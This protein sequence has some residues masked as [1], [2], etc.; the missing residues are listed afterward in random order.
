MNQDIELKDIRKLPR[1]HGETISDEYLD[2]MGHMN[3]QWY[4]ALFSKAVTGLFNPVSY[5]HLT[6]P[7]K[8]I[9]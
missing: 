8:R 5:T 3:V 6:L 7:T 9:V 1:Y 2:I 4:V